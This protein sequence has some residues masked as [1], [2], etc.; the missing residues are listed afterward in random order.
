ML[1]IRNI[2]TIIE[3]IYQENQLDLQY[4]VNSTL[5]SPMSFNVSTNTLAYNYLQVNGY[6]S[7]V[8]IQESEED[9]VRIMIYREL[10]YYITF[11][12]H[13]PD[14]RTLLYGGDAEVAELKAEI[15]TNAWDYGRELVPDRLKQSYDIVRERDGMLL[16]GRL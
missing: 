11:K 6:M 15:E 14:M 9:F 12:K 5:P 2:E 3:E 4:E 10:G 1:Y 8:K 7:K 13:R 16:N